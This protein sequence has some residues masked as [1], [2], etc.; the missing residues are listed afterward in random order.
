[1][2]PNQ[3]IDDFFVITNGQSLTLQLLRGRVESAGT[4]KSV[5]I[6]L[7]YDPLGGNPSGPANNQPASWERIDTLMGNNFN[8]D[9]A[10]GRVVVGDGT[11]RVVL[12]LQQT[13]SSAMAVEGIWVGFEI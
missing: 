13:G 4:G 3:V 6:E 5:R 11:S 12:R 8:Q 9:A 2:S 10:Q 1:M 7:F